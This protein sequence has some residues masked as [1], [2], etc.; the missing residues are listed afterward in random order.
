MKKQ[1]GNILWTLLEQGN[2]FLVTIVFGMIFAKQF[3]P[4]Y[5]GR[6]SL[7]LAILSLVI[8]FSK[9]GLDS[10]LIRDFILN[11]KKE[12][13]IFSSAVIISLFGTAISI[14]I[15]LLTISI[16]EYKDSHL[17]L[18]LVLSTVLNFSYISEHYTKAK[19]DGKYYTIINAIV[20]IPGFA[21]KVYMLQFGSLDVVVYIIASESVIFSLLLI[22]LQKTRYRKIALIS[23]ANI[24]QVTSL[25]KTSL[26]MLISSLAIML[27]MRID[28]LMIKAFLGD[29]E[30]GLYT[31]MT[32]L[33]E[34]EL[35]IFVVI[36]T[37]ILPLIVSLKS[38]S[39]E[40][41]ILFFKFAFSFGIY[42]SVFLSVVSI[43]FSE[44]IIL[45]LYG[46]DYIIGLDVYLVVI[47]SLPI[48][49][50]GSIKS[51]YLISEGKTK[52][53]TI[54]AIVA[55]TINFVMNLI[56][57][58]YLGIVGAAYSTLLSL[59]IANFLWDF[60]DKDLT[61]LNDILLSSIIFKFR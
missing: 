33:Y 43:Y 18:I 1:I 21:I 51:K 12:S 49:C 53:L 24:N 46:K 2:K 23:S 20:F 39:H 27:Y 36:S 25:A 30:L 5:F 14:I 37:S 26:P 54:R 3:G 16:V 48:A 28:Q 29:Y 40:K 11:K 56:L 47:L 15:V 32:R 60:L 10:I 55:L 38:S 44:N 13:D 42:A 22:F 6:L 9:L 7:L 57:I 58:P 45:M 31:A 34:M 41:Y 50:I 8:S 59:F 35:L 17:L 52:K 4:E 61:V 19:L